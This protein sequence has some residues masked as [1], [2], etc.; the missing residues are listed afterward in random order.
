ML[1]SVRRPAPRRRSKIVSRRCVR[2]SN[3]GSSREL[4]GKSRKALK[5]TG[6]PTR[7]Q[8]SG[9]PRRASRRRSKNGLSRTVY[10]LLEATGVWCR[11]RYRLWCAARPM[12]IKG[13]AYIMGAFEHPTRLAKDKSV[14]QLHAESAFGALQDAGLSKEDV[15]GYFCAGDAPGLGPLAMADYMN[16]RLRHLDSTEVGGASY[17]AHVSHAAQA[18]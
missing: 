5:P 1:S 14:A 13:K 3:I 18:I 9:A 15:D 10:W 17:I 2:A 6:H 8:G 4:S 16:L 11:N 12:S 7:R